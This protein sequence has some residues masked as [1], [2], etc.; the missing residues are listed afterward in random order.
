MTR[1][2]FP[3]VS[4]RRA[5]RR[6]LACTAAALACAAIAAGAA[7][8]AIPAAPGGPILVVT[9]N[10]DSFGSYL[11]EIL[12]GEG[13]NEFDLA[14]VGSV[15]PQTLAAHPV[16]LLGHTSLSDGQVAM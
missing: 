11:P 8:A 6:L 13:L 7:P 1:R 3:T 16:V 12:R 10:A 15:D 9:S 5:S 14:D 2:P 4:I